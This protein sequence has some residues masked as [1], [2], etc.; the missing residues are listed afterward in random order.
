MKPV[1]FEDDH[2]LDAERFR[3]FHYFGQI[4]DTR[5]ENGRLENTVVLEEVLGKEN[6]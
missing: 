5:C 2:T 1:R 4:Y 3:H 6:Y